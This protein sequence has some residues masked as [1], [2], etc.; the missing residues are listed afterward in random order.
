MSTYSERL[1]ASSSFR[2]SPV[3]HSRELS[4]KVQLRRESATYI[5]RFLIYRTVASLS[6]PT[7]PL[8]SIRVTIPRCHR[9]G[10]ERL[11][12]LDRLPP[13]EKQ[14]APRPA[15]L[16]KP[17]HRHRKAGREALRVQGVNRVGEEGRGYH[18]PERQTY[19]V[20][21]SPYSRLCHDGNDAVQYYYIY[22]KLTISQPVT[23]SQLPENA[24][25]I[26]AP[27]RS[28][29]SA[30]TKDPGI[31]SFS[32]SPLHDWSEKWPCLCYHR[33]LDKSYGG[34]RKRSRRS[35]R[36]RRRFWSICSKIRICARYMRRELRLCRK[37]SSLRGGYAER[38][39]VSAEC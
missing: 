11:L 14:S 18:S 22:Q 21:R 17:A 26:P 7:P 13:R 27:L 6:L 32:N 33:T 4:Q 15:R 1:C 28:K 39:A 20:S 38:G 12:Q 25:I 19:S 9:N 5:R 36:P 31:F 23:P 24:A 30:A 37:I 2:P 35:K 29:K 16:Q 8:Y 10:P 3:L 34:S